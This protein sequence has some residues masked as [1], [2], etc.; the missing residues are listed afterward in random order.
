VPP[1][2]DVVGVIQHDNALNLCCYKED[3]TGYGCLPGKYCNPTY[4]LTTSV[5]FLLLRI[6]CYICYLPCIQVRNSLIFGGANSAVQWYCAPAMGQIE[7]ISAKD[8]ASA[9][10]PERDKS[11]P[12]IRATGPPLIRPGAKPLQCPSV[13]QFLY[14]M[15]TES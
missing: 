3:D 8:R 15:L 2:K 12:Q 7:A 9:I 4:S 14:I 1:F 13:S 6:T 5:T 10:V 11:M